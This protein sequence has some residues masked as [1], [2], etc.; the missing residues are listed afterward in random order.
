[1]PH[2][3]SGNDAFMLGVICKFSAYIGSSIMSG[4]KRTDLASELLRVLSQNGGKEK[5]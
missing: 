4:N 2:S 3:R 5:R 1:M